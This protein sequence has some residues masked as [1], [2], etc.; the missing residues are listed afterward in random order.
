[1]SNFA[2]SHRSYRDDLLS[3]NDPEQLMA[4]SNAALQDIQVTPI[5]KFGDPSWILP[6]EWLPAGLLQAESARRVDFAGL[7]PRHGT[8]P[9][10][11]GQESA[12][13]RAG[14]C[15][16]LVPLSSKTGIKQAK[17]STALTYLKILIRMGREALTRFPHPTGKTLFAH[18]TREQIDALVEAGTTPDGAMMRERVIN[19][20]LNYHQRGL[21]ADIPLA[22][23]HD[24]PMKVVEVAR[25]GQ[26][27]VESAI[28]GDEKL[29]QPFPDHFLSEVGWRCLWL[30]EEL[31]P[32]LLD[33]WERNFTRLDSSEGKN[34]TVIAA[35]RARIEAHVWVS[36]SGKPITRLPFPVALKDGCKTV[37]TD[38]WPPTN[39]R[40]VTQMVAMLQMA[41]FTLVAA[42]TGARWSELSGATVGSLESMEDGGG[43][44]YARTWKL[45]DDHTGVEREWPLPREAVF[46]IRQQER[47]A[48]I[49]HPRTTDRHLWVI[50]RGRKD[51]VS[52]DPLQRVN[53]P[54]EDFIQALGIDELL[55]GIRPHSHR[56]RKTLARLA[57]L[58]LVGA[59]KILMSLFG[60]RQIEMTL[61]YIL[62]NPNVAA[63]IEDASRAY[64]YA[65]GTELVHD[66]NEYELTGCGAERLETAM[67]FIRARRAKDAFGT[68]STEEVV[69]ILMEAGRSFAV[70]RPGII[71]LRTPSEEGA[72]THYCGIDP[73]R[74]TGDCQF[75][76]NT[77]EAER[78]ANEVLEALSAK[79]RDPEV[80]KQE[81][82]AAAYRGQIAARLKASESLRN[83]WLSD[84]LIATIW[85][86]V[87]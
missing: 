62:S 85:K 41:H 8:M 51:R 69:D 28:I 32:T 7:V 16:L 80:A 65:L 4:R 24:R 83:R 35:R 17:P 49:M 6:A 84:E 77:P 66:S 3:I 15:L 22:A 52:G 63:E 26:K 78:D 45:E 25:R 57:A 43:R 1:M 27:K 48:T 86:D 75:R 70:V 11:E 64:L 39:H 38:N 10:T 29:Y 67:A 58:A 18:L 42:A 55:N 50:M 71:C 60:H 2:L 81:L 36:T 37:V 30:V 9:V 54:Y 13:R 14:L 12:I 44:W 59:P 20:L 76:V 73:A 34:P 31:G 5:S 53:E 47:L 21:L 61:R 74:C 87:A 68:T 40:A 33:F 79:L 82:V 72:C 19:H 23:G 56:W 46:A